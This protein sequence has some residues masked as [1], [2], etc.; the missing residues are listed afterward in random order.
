VKIAKLAI[1]SAE[2]ASRIL[3]MNFRL[4]FVRLMARPPVSKRR[5]PVRPRATGVLAQS[6][7]PGGLLFS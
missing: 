1:T 4:K 6:I 7:G 2:V 5:H 3:W